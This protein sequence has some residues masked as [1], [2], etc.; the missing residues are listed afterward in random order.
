M[1]AAAASVDP[2]SFSTAAKTVGAKNSVIIPRVINCNIL[3]LGLLA[4]SLLI[5]VIRFTEKAVFL[6]S[7][8]GLCSGI[9]QQSGCSL[10]K[11]RL[12]WPK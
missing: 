9:T 8:S 7:R 11:A 1:A 3:C 10:R 6:H 5:I 12:G 2:P 4:R